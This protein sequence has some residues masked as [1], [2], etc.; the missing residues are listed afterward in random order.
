MIY[1]NCVLICCLNIDVIP[2]FVEPPSVS[3]ISSFAGYNTYSCVVMAGWNTRVRWYASITVSE[4]DDSIPEHSLN[5]A[6]LPSMFVTYSKQNSSATLNTTDTSYTGGPLDTVMPVHNAT[7]HVHISEINRNMTLICKIT[8]VNRNFLSQYNISEASLV[9]TMQQPIPTVPVSSS[10]ASSNMVLFVVI[11]LVV[12]LL[13]AIAVVLGVI[14]YYKRCCYLKTE[15]SL[16]PAT[17]GQFTV[18]MPISLKL[19]NENKEVEFPR[20][21]VTLLHVLGK[22]IIYSGIRK[23]YIIIY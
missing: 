12:C 21:K 4:D 1:L 18:S 8:G 2:K 3:K 14:V 19:V 6:D 13:I 22:M 16:M 15:S 7:L 10:P 11:G 5:D 20:N 9:Y 23:C 17:F